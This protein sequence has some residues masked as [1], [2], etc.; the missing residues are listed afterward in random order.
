VRFPLS[1]PSIAPYADRVARDS[2][3]GEVGVTFLGTSSVLVRDARTALLVD[4]FFTRPSL[5]KVAT[6]KIGPDRPTI[7]ACL[8]RA[9]IDTLD[10]VLCAHSH[11]DHALDSPV[12]ARILDAP[13]IGSASTMNL[14]RGQGLPERLLL[15]AR[16]NQTLV[17]GDF[18]VTLVEGTHSPGDIAPGGI[19]IPLTPPA[20]YRAWRSGECYS[21]V[22]RHPAGTLLVHAS[23][24][25]VPGRLA[26][27]RADT[28]YLGI[29]TLGRQTD[30]FRQ[31]YWHEV[32]R[33]TGASAVVPIH[34]DDFTRPLDRPLRAMPYLMD[35]IRP[36]L[37]FL[38]GQCERDGIAFAMP[39]SWRQIDPFALLSPM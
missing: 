4:G 7:D 18:E 30:R 21:I 15:R 37:E 31:E 24:N 38:I 26:G 36:A 27:H 12:I 11:Y 17:F 6:S 2:R 28:V 34:W 32:V 14:G 39:T 20:R 16:D 9:G 19:D 35:D 22:L 5:W 8:S 25:Y 23:A 33:T 13:L 10:A 1:R 3:S 29:G